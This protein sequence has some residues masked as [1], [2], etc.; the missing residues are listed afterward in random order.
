MT[1]PHSYQRGGISWLPEG[2]SSEPE[3]ITDF[4]FMLPAANG[5]VSKAGKRR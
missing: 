4:N 2:E 1:R 5:A 3:R